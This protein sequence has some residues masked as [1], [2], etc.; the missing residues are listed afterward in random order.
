MPEFERKLDARLILS[1]LATGIMTFAGILEET[2]MN[3]SFPT[4]MEEF[5][6]AL[7]YVQWITTGYLLALIA[8]MPTSAFLKRKLK[9]MRSFQ[10]KIILG[11]K[12]FYERGRKC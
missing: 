7:S 4:L 12:S 10:K 8:M 5:G 1:I 6:I 3:I 2:A 9:R 11:L